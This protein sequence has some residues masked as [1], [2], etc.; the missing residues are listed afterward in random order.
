MGV[1][2]LGLGLIGTLNVL[3]PETVSSET[4]SPLNRNAL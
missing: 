1:E 4:K 2:V 3:S